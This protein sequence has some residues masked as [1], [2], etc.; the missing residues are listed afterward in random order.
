MVERVICSLISDLMR[1]DEE[2]KRAIS[3][4]AELK[5]TGITKT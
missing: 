1:E 5:P 3:L 2:K 4:G